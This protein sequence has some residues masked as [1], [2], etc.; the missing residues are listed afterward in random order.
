MQR[1][2]NEEVYLRQTAVPSD[3]KGKVKLI[4]IS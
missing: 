1:L 4:D 2:I 3:H